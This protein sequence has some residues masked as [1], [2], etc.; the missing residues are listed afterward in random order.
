MSVY[1]EVL[2]AV[3][4]AAEATQLYNSITIGPLPAENGLAIAFSPGSQEETYQD[5]NILLSLPCVLNGKHESQKMVVEALGK[6][7]A[8]LTRAKDYPRSER[9]QITDISTI[10]TPHYVD[11]ENGQWLYGSSLKIKVYTKGV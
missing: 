2:L 9:W 3:V 6:I 4:K 10:A 1:D 7:H 11:R 5:K 8:A